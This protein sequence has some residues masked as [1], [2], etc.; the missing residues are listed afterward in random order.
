MKA[1]LPDNESQRIET[2]LEYKILDTPSEAAF[3][4]LTY[5]ASYI[6]GTPIALISLID[7]NRQ[8]FKSKVGLE[9]LEASRDQAFCAHAILQPE[10]FVVPDATSDQRFA[11]NPLVTSDP[12]IRFYTGVPLINPEG[13]ALGTLCV[14]DRVPRNL[15]PEQ[16][17][18][19]RALGRQVIK[20]LELRRNLASL[21]LMTNER[22]QAQNMRKQF[23]KKVAG[24]F[25]LASII[26]ILI[27]TLSYQNTKVLINT[28]KD[29]ITTQKS[30]NSLEELLSAMK[31][32]ETGQRGYIITGEET[33]LQ[34][35]KSALAV[36][37]QEIAEINIFTASNPNQQKQLKTLSNLITAKLAFVKSTIDLRQE[38][39]F[40]PSLQLLRTN[41]GKNLMD[42]IR[43]IV[44]EME[45]EER[46]L[47]N[48]QLKAAKVNARNT[49]LTL[50]I[51]ISL[52]FIIL[53]IVYYLIYREVT[54][55]KLTEETLHK[56]RNFISAVLD[57]AS[58]L[59]AV[60]DSQGKIV[61]F[62]QACEQTMKR[63]AIVAKP[64]G[65]K[66]QIVV[67]WA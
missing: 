10:V 8:W 32:A 25:G 4:D 49:M 56:E 17:E 44:R 31:D 1:P 18:A 19:L 67:A 2:L 20:Q 22:K 60:L 28:N 33:Y 52:S 37:D 15:S 58:A 26:L 47:L 40:N 66:F 6:C 30:I 39:G 34:P 46:S 57:T 62:N 3:D 24:G 7:T 5:L 65:N 35:Y 48:Q 59:V 38:R 36:I 11:N 27:G 50:A 43:K 23:F 29:V 45:D 9:A 63:Q 64:A 61:R 42:N 12:N 14:I 54:E 55:R 13:Y 41:L 16:I 53:A 21:V 51:A